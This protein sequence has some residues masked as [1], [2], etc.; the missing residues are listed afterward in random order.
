[1]K[2]TLL[3]DAL[4]KRKAKSFDTQGFIRE[5]TKGL[6]SPDLGAKTVA[7]LGEGVKDETL[8]KTANNRSSTDDLSPSAQELEV[9]GHETKSK[10]KSEPKPMKQMD[11]YE[12][13]FEEDDDDDESPKEVGG[14]NDDAVFDESTYEKVKNRKPKSI[15]ERM[16]LSLGKKKGK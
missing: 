14:K 9:K 2:S 5:P 11:D 6:D 8:M 4:K 13:D 16:Q 15:Y 7:V 3:S 12:D 1:M 10:P